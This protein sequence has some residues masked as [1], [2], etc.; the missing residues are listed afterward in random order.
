MYGAYITI[1]GAVLTVLLNMWWIPEFRYMGAAW[2]TF[3]CYA[4]MMVVSY[5]QGQKY[6]PVPYP[7]KKLLAYLVIVTLLYL[8]QLGITALTPGWTVLHI[9]TGLVL[10]GAF[11]LFILKIEKR[12]FEKLPY[13][14]KY[15]RRTPTP[16]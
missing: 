15:L 8:V 10:M 12:E 2:S 4:F 6:Y 13:V 11:G 14:G 1:V 16:A 9:M 3:F 7:W 5:V